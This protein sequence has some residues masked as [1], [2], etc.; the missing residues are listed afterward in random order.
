MRISVVVPTYRRHDLLRRCLAALAAQ[1]FEGG[2]YEVIVAD[3]AADPATRRLVETEA[4]TANCDMRYVPVEKTHGP[5]AAR[6]AGWRAARSEFIAFTDDD[7]LPQPGWLAAGVEALVGG[8]DA[9]WG[10]LEMPLPPKPT[11]YQ[12]DAAG[13]A[14]AV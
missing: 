4:E 1:Q 8:A 6:N 7:C 13:L 12:R 5:A 14:A 9:A 2:D 11:D 3:D 10:R